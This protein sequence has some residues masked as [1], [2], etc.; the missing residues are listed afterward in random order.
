MTGDAHK[1]L[2][3]LPFALSVE[4][5]EGVGVGGQ[6]EEEIETDHALHIGTSQGTH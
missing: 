2:K 3:R 1:G 4:R 6:C 5:G